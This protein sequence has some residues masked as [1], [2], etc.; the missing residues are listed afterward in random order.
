MNDLVCADCGRPLLE[1]DVAQR[2]PTLCESCQGA[3]A[4]DLASSDVQLGLSNR[5]ATA[6]AD[7]LELFAGIDDGENTDYDDLIRLAALIRQA[8]SEP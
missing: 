1:G 6:I 5:D 7:A 4:Y 8:T 3:R 2:N